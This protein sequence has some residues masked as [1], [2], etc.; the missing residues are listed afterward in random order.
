MSNKLAFIV[1]AY[2]EEKVLNHSIGVLED[3]LLKLQRQNKIDDQSYLL[4]IDDGS[5]DQ[6][7]A[8]IQKLSKNSL[9]NVKGIRFSRNFGHQNAIWA[10]LMQAKEDADLTIT[11]D[12]DL[13]DDP[14]MIPK[15][16]DQ[17]LAGNQIVYGVRNNR[18]SDSF[19]KRESAN[20]FYKLMNLLGVKIIPNH[21][22]F[23]LMTVKAVNLLS[24]Y[25]ERQLFI[26]G[27]VPQLGLS[28][29]KV[30]YK[31]QKRIA[32]ESK[33]TIQ[34][35]L[36]LAWNGITLFSTSLLKVPTILGGGFLLLGT[37]LLLEHVVWKHSISMNLIS[38]WIIGGAILLSLG[39]IAEYVGKTFNE[40]KHRPR[41]LVAERTD[42][43]E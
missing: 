15:M 39:I 11:I 16:I 31:R 20:M 4:I 32:G 7:W 33:Y 41:Y 3:I 27:L 2:N 23:R 8:I 9:V 29:S 43:N 30:D 42:N 18:D 12:A 5:T 24:Q 25:H 21:A 19:F 13:Q 34:K 40:I 38:L 26:R 36:D 37:V 35:M 17:Y 6:T 14:K 1:P 28:T 22:D 10:G